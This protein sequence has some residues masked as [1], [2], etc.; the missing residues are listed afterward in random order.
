MFSAPKSRAT[1]MALEI[2]WVGPDGLER[3]VPPLTVGETKS[4]IWLLRGTPRA[5]WRQRLLAREPALAG[6]RSI[7]LVGLTADL[8]TVS[9]SI[10]RKCLKEWNLFE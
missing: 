3:T 8:D 4:W 10:R 6:A 2:V 9:P 1:A 5:D 7:R